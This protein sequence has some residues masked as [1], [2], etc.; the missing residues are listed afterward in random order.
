MK[1]YFFAKVAK[2]VRPGI[3]NLNIEVSQTVNNSFCLRVDGDGSHHYLKAAGIDVE[4]CYFD[5][6]EDAMM[7]A[8]RVAAAAKSD[9]Y[10]QTHNEISTYDM[11][12]LMPYRHIAGIKEIM[13]YNIEAE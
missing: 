5:T 11:N 8:K 12:S 13:L 3:L 4:P 1:K 2:V 10:F 6:E 7:A 9:G